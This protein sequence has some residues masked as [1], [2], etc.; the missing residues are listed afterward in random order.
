MNINDGV[1]WETVSN[2][3]T[4]ALTGLY[5]LPSNCVMCRGSNSKVAVI[6]TSGQEGAIIYKDDDILFHFPDGT[7]EVMEREI[8]TAIFKDFPL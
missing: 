3:L 4:N 8:L 5:E 7:W 2:A 1:L 6:D